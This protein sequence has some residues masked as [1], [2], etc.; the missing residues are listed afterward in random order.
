MVTMRPDWD[1]VER[2]N[3]R[4]QERLYRLFAISVVVALAV[5][6]YTRPYRLLRRRADAAPFNVVF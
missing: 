3:R 6:A 4:S 1:E 2:R 5:L